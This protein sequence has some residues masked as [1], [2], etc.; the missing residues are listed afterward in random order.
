MPRRDGPTGEAITRSA[1]AF[2]LHTS[3]LRRL[4]PSVA[5]NLLNVVPAAGL[6]WAVLPADEALSATRVVGGAV[7]VLGLY[8]NSR[9]IPVVAG[10][11]RDNSSHEG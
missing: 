3:G 9:D 2:L 5:V 10:S 11:E 1:A 6:G 4:V 7:V 8:R